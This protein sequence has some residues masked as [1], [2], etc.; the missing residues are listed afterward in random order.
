M[1]KKKIAKVVIT[2]VLVIGMCCALAFAGEDIFTR[3]ESAVGGYEE[4][5]WSLI[6]KL[7]VVIGLIAG[8]VYILAPDDKM[9]QTGKKC[10]YCLFLPCFLFFLIKVNHNLRKS[11]RCFSGP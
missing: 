8:A 9:C 6:Q 7:V 4:S 11:C 2:Q 10:V 1:E 5:V 3:A